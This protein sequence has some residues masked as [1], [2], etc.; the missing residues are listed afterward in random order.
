M[1]FIAILRFHSNALFTGTDESA[2]ENT[3]EVEENYD[4]HRFLSLKYHERY[5]AELISKKVLPESGI[6]LEKVPER[7]PE[8][9]Q[10]LVDMG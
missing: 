1:F 6:L 2:H 8:F 9:H 5:Y 10:R 4:Q 7:L 3:L